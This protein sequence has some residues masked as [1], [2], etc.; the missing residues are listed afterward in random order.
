MEI[1]YNGKIYTL[2]PQ[3]PTVSALAIREGRIIALGSDQAIRTEFEGQGTHLDLHGQAVIPGLIDAHIH[4]EHYALGLQK[5][6]CETMTRQECLRRVTERVP[7]T[8]TGDWILGHGWNQNSWADGFGTAQEL[9]AVAPDHP[10]YL[11]AK[12]LHAAWANTAAMHLAGLTDQ[13]PDPSGG[14]LGRDS[15][16]KLNGIF[17][18]SAMQLIE[19]ALPEITVEKVTQ[20]LRFVQPALWQMGLTGVHDYDQRRCFS[21]LQVLQTAGELRLRV[22][23]GIPLDDLPHAV[24]VGLRTGFGNDFLRVGSI[25]AFADG[26]LGPQTAAML[27]PYEGNPDNQGMLLMDSEELSEHGHLA[28][29]NGFSLAVHA[30]GDRAIHE[31]LDAFANLRVYEAAKFS[32]SRPPLRHRIEHVQVIHPSDAHRLAE[33]GVI[34]SMQPIHAPSDMLMADQHWGKRAALAYAW[35]TQ[36]IHGAVL[37]FGSDAPVESP[38]PF[39]GIHAAVT[40]RRLDGS[41][42]AEGWYPEQRLTVLEALQG[43][44][45]GAAYAAGMEDR[46]GQLA[47]GFYADL[48]LLSVDP[49]TC[50]PEQIPEIKPLATMV[51]GEWVYQ[52]G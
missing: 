30:I 40:R 43:F 36:K 26:A 4:L 11:T 47:S 14:K 13:T 44:T 32:G 18:E 15:Q 46:L 1:L 21:A 2:N 34:A 49:F 37:A 41:P 12:S 3:K 25:K 22:I 51:N 10:V 35:R 23:K 45:T 7:T 28:V 24:A 5:V 9:D 50:P 20:A 31:V 6:D 29:A 27:Q 8:P 48:V 19:R 33:L 16:G 39:W 52:K 42:G 38:H 17:F